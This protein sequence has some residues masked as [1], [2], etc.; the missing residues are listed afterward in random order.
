MLDNHLPII[1]VEK[2]RSN[3]EWNQQI[4]QTIRDV[5]SIVSRHLWYAE[6][7]SYGSLTSLIGFEAY[8]NF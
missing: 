7:N 4:F 6:R 8:E 1:A 5:A 3:P 2:K